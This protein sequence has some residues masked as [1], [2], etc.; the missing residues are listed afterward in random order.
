ML[1]PD[2]KVELARWAWGRQPVDVIAQYPVRAS[3]VEWVGV[4]KHLQPRQYSISSSPLIDPRL[5]YLT[6]SVIRFKNDQ[7]RQRKGVTSAYLA[8]AAP[9]NPVPVFVQRSAHFHPPADAATPMVMVAPAPGSLPS[10]ASCRSAVPADT[11]APTGCSSASS[12]APLTSTTA[13]SS[14]SCAATGP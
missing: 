6:V 3:A 9:N 5:I 7:G 14:T 8:D 12:V 1:R 13:T 10:S 2:N 4:L 11:E